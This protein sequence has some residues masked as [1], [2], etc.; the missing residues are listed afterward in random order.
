M[1]RKR[2]RG[3]VMVDGKPVPHFQYLASCLEDLDR[4][5]VFKLIEAIATHMENYDRMGEENDLAFY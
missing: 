5:P 2:N 4:K 3:M 1:A